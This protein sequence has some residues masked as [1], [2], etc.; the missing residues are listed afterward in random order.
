ME[1]TT[2]TDISP[3]VT[4]EALLQRARDMAPILLQ[5]AKDAED[6]RRIPDE[7]MREI[8]DAGLMRVMQPRRFGGYEYDFGLFVKIAAE[9]ARGCG[10]SSWVY[11]NLASH[12][13]MVGMWCA[14]AQDEVWARSPDEC[15][16]SSLA[17]PAGKA[18]RVEGGYRIR[19]Q[20][21]FS[22]GID[23]S[24]WA[25]LAAVVEE[26]AGHPQEHRVFLLPEADYDAVDNWFVT[27]L[28][29]T[30]SKDVKVEDKFVAEHMT[31]SPLDWRGGDSPGS[32]VN[33]SAL[34][35][36][37]VIS[38]FPYCI[39]GVS[40]GIA[41]GALDRYV[42]HTRKRVSTYTGAKV[43]QFS[44][45]HISLA[46]AGA[47]IEAAERM[48]DYDCAEVTRIA[49]EGGT[50]TL[51]QKVRYRRNG[52]YTTT[53]CVRAVDILFSLTGGA[54]LFENNP[55]QRSFRDIHA[56]KAHI[57]LAWEPAASLYGRV[58]L[59][60]PADSPLL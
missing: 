52:A 42:A 2:P 18:T 1:K 14:E 23:N 3:G 51:D 28:S 31:V 7:T 15:V 40:L 22:S 49:D 21:P 26:D 58:A 39:S 8:H 46:E 11:S 57:A 20:W 33:P 25:M 6:A 13:W 48:M 4:P 24:R 44:N 59:G 10:S 9:L 56:C 38:I 47:L 34:F 35:K 12:Q 32:P 43:A 36:L 41:Q 55:I 60:L 45:V 53:L 29:A 16:C 27:G 19:G 37:P 5:R 50:P 17:F 54:A 30:G